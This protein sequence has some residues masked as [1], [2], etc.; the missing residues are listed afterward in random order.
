MFARAIDPR[1]LIAR[2]LRDVLARETFASDAD[3]KEALKLRCARLHVP[4][5]AAIIDRAC[6]LVA[7]NRP[8]STPETPVRVVAPEPAPCTRDDAARILRRFGVAVDQV[9]ATRRLTPDEYLRRRFDADRARAL[10]LVTDAIL[11]A[12]ARCDALAKESK[13]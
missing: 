5:D 12:D 1:R 8:L 7:T 11:E 6:D 3:V 4:Y 13:S 9:P 10:Q 2:L